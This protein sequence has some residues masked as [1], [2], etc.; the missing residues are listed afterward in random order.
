MYK[1]MARSLSIFSAAG[2]LSLSGLV[3]SQPAA[4]AENLDIQTFCGT[5]LF[6]YTVLNQNINEIL[7]NKKSLPLRRLVTRQSTRIP[8]GQ[9]RRFLQLS[10]NTLDQQSLLIENA[11]PGQQT[12][13]TRF[14]LCAFDSSGQAK[15]LADFELGQPGH[16][17]TSLHSFGNLRDR[18]LA[19]R[20]QNLDP[21]QT[22]SFNLDW[23][24]PNEGQPR[25]VNKTAPNRPLTGFADIHVHQTAD[26]AF[27][28]GWY[29]GSHREG[30]LAERLP[31]CQGNDHAAFNF[32]FL[33]GQALLDPHAPQHFSHPA[34]DAWPAWN[35]IKHQQVAAVDLKSAHE[36]GLGLMVASVVNNQWLASAMLVAKQNKGQLP[37]NDM[38]SAKVQLNSLWGMHDNTDWYRIVQDPWE[39]RRVA[40]AGQLPVVLAV[41]I[42]HVFP[43]GDGPWKQQLHDLYAMGV[44]TVQFAHEVNTHFSGAAYHRN[45]FKPLG[46][47]KALFKKE[48]DYDPGDGVHNP[49]GLSP[50]G[51][52]LLDEMV[53]LHMLIDIS[54][55]SMEAQRQ[56][57]EYVRDKHNGYPLY[58]SHTRFGPLLIKADAEELK[59][60]VTTP[61]TA[62]YI[63][64]TGGMI[65]LRSGENPM[66]QY[67]PRSGQTIANSCDGS[68]RSFA[69]MYQAFDDLGVSVAIAS[70]FNGFITQLGPRYGEQACFNAPLSER[71][72]QIAAQG[73]APRGSAALNEFHT[74]GLA[75]IGLL[76]A[77]IEDF[78]NLGVNTQN[79]DHS[80]EKFVQMWERA[81]D[82]QRKLLP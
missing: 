65:G 58:N 76:P 45:I 14:T 50:L 63:R 20:I 19:L 41:E 11:Q 38:D 8:V 53:R 72:K 33:T 13:R 60:F 40:A 22:A 55:L 71:A 32:R 48:I 69:Q 74:Q 25:P 34:T 31:D 78:K 77:V 6:P 23:Q 12:V 56:I 57:Y 36:N 10:P 73:S 49:I 47:I 18:R 79:I 52:E 28:G 61:E 4:S 44:R 24:I 26:L 21:K 3:Q 27:A 35:D 7:E 70:D 51:Y 80:A 39:A 2:L 64:R 75:H 43:E 29:W 66:Q 30:P 42:D 16:K 5:G 54:H 15:I 1:Q 37:A 67:S 62:T 17:Q 9:Q 68:N 59:E 82:S 46:Q 81:Y